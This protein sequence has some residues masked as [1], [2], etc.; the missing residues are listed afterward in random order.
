MIEVVRYFH[1]KHGDVS[2]CRNVDESAVDPDGSGTRA[3]AGGV[4]EDADDT[5][6]C[7]AQL[8]HRFELEDKN[9]LDFQLSFRWRGGCKPAAAEEQ[10]QRSAAWKTWVSWGWPWKECCDCQIAQQDGRQNGDREHA[11]GA[12]NLSL[13]YDSLS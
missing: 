11:P 7:T 5:I 13:Y 2:E 3:A 10:A 6:R 9:E 8:Q 12:C 4:V 1:L